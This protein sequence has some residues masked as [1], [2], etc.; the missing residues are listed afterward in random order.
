MNGQLIIISGS[1]Q[2]IHVR[3]K[4][5][6]EQFCVNN[7]VAHGEGGDRIPFVGRRC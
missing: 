5:Q 2:S 1:I 7:N 4:Q 3:L 6:V